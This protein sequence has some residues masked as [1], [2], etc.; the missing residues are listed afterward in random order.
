[1]FGNCVFN[2]ACHAMLNFESLTLCAEWE[3]TGFGRFDEEIIKNTHTH[4]RA[5]R[6]RGKRQEGRVRLHMLELCLLGTHMG[7]RER[8]TE[9]KQLSLKE[10][11]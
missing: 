10:S 2:I 11:F 4:A 3:R 1:M 9:G 8:G 6:A 7:K 5:H